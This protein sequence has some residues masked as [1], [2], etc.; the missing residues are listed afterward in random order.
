M[1]KGSQSVMMEKRIVG[2]NQNR[3]QGE[4]MEGSSV[5][6]KMVD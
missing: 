6:R 2:N 1:K 5:I 3:Q 4:V